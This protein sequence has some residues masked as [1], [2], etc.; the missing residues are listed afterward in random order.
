M[1]GEERRANILKRLQETDTPLSG[2]ALAKEFHVSRQIIVQD[3]ALMRAENNGIVSTN[4]GYLLR[5]QKTENTQPKRVFFVK[6]ATEQVLEEFKI[7]L[8][9]G[10]KILDVAVEHEIYGQICVDLLIETESDAEEFHNK[11]ISCRDNP[12][13]VLT[14]DCHYHTVCAPSEKLLDLIEGELRRKGFLLA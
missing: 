7:I 12:L 3:I 1:T 6:H 8:E 9:L 4:K 5:S 10:G 2:T 11:L 14:D 13:K